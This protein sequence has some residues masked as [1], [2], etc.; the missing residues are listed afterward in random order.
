MCKP[1]IIIS[2]YI[3]CL[4]PKAFIYIFTCGSPV[5]TVSIYILTTPGYFTLRVLRLFCWNTGH[6]WLQKCTG[7]A[8]Y[9]TFTKKCSTHYA[10]QGSK[11]NYMSH[12][13]QA[14]TVSLCTSSNTQRVSCSGVFICKCTSKLQ[15]MSLSHR[16]TNT[17]FFQ[18][19]DTAIIC[20]Q[21]QALQLFMTIHLRWMGD[22]ISLWSPYE[23]KFIRTFNGLICR[24]YNYTKFTNCSYAANLDKAIK[25]TTDQDHCTADNVCSVIELSSTIQHKFKLETSKLL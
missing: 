17:I 11:Y 23:W 12:M 21:L 20:L 18:C 25:L 9:T 10:G 3:S 5:S 2:L 13:L 16:Q 24:K 4:K 6:R 14:A 22:V 19:K 1:Y 15:Y 7:S 8:I